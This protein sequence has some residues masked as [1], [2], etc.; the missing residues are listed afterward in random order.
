MGRVARIFNCQQGTGEVNES[1]TRKMGTWYKSELFGEKL[2]SLSFVE[3]VIRNISYKMVT[4][5]EKG[6]KKILWWWGGEKNCS[7]VMIP[8]ISFREEL[9]F[10]Y[11]VNFMHWGKTGL[12]VSDEVNWFNTSQWKLPKLRSIVFNAALLKSVK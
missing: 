11:K 7:W 8:I 2:L 10:K 3:L 6:G 5:I 1:G 12:D 4:L 9:I